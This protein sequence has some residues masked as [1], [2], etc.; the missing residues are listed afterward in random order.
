MF[1]V[2]LRIF[3]SFIVHHLYAGRFDGVLPL[4]GILALQPVIMGLGNIMADGL[5]VFELPQWSFYAFAGSGTATLAI[6]IPLVRA[7]A[8]SGAA[9]GMLI[10]AG[11]YSAILACGFL[12]LAVRQQ[13]AIKTPALVKG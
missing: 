8:L 9:W 10:S 3:G 5:R 12:P 4:L 13:D 2:A 11:V 7:F 1:A 6:G